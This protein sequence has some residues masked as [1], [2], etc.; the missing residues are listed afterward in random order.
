MRSDWDSATKSALAGTAAV[1]GLAI[2]A[3]VLAFAP[4]APFVP[5]LLTAAFAGTSIAFI[6][7]IGFARPLLADLARERA[8]RAALDAELRVATSRRGF[9]EQLDCALDMA[10]TEDEAVAVVGRAL[11]MLL[12]DRDNY[13]LLAPPQ[14][15][16]VTWSI[17][18]GPDGLAEPS[19][20][21]EAMRCTALSLGH[22]V[23]NESS[24]ALDACPHLVDHGWEVSS[25]C[26]PIRVG[27]QH[28]G[29]AHSAGPAGD[30]PDE[31]GRRLLEVVTRRVGARI[32]ALRASRQHADHVALDPLT[33]VPNHTIVQRRLRELMTD[34]QPFSVAFCDLDHFS[35]Y[36]DDHGTDVGDQALRIY[37]D[38][39]GATLRPGDVI[40][41]FAGDRFLCLFPNCSARNAAAA[42]ERVRE[43]LVLELAMQELDPF[44]TSVGIVDSSDADT[45]EDL[46]EVA[47]IAL[48]VAKNGGGNRVV[49]NDFDE[50]RLIDDL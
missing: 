24:H 41:R 42:M 11:A 29:V 8:G 38:V 50:I 43:S 17:P 13:V 9:V 34:G 32:A 20:L 46:L 15:P 12:P 30:L 31:E 1:A 10:D 40:A 26:V 22:T 47:D 36:N 19:I 5:V 45:V 23:T 14:E 33:K 39:M 3:L 7:Y 37:A 18:A 2:A 27:E 25:L 35:R 48:A 44:T 6:A 28:L 49:L 4:D 16:R 21:G